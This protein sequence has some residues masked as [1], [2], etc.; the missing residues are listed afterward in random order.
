MYGSAQETAL[1][2]GFKLLPIMFSFLQSL[3]PLYVKAE[4]DIQPAVQEDTQTLDTLLLFNETAMIRV[5]CL[6]ENE[7]AIIEFDETGTRM[8][9]NGISIEPYAGNFAVVVG[10]PQTGEMYLKKF[11]HDLRNTQTT[12]SGSISSASM[13]NR[14]IVYSGIENGNRFIPGRHGELYQTIS[15][16]ST[17]EEFR[18][19]IPHACVVPPQW[20]LRPEHMQSETNPEIETEGIKFIR[21]G[22]GADS[23]LAGSTIA[24]KTKSP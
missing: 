21:I 9:I 5:V 17:I 2:K 7:P 8:F 3:Q 18:R 1:V 14:L 23:I 24:L 22:A 6:S 10:N 11:G 16:F 4:E 20:D 12:V 13:E 19:N 15:L